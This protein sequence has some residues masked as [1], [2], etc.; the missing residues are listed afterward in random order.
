MSAEPPYGYLECV[1]HGCVNQVP[2]YLNPADVSL[3]PKCK[4]C[5]TKRRTHL[6]EPFCVHG[7]RLPSHGEPA[8]PCGCTRE[9]NLDDAT[10]DWV[11]IKQL[12]EEM[13]AA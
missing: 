1:Y 8:P 7:T 3:H 13:E 10:W 6:H 11:S 9:K 12:I 2:V 5:R 4:S